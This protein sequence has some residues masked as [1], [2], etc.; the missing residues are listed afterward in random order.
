[1]PVDTLTLPPTLTTA[2]L[3]DARDAYAS[4]AIEGTSLSEAEAMELAAEFYASDVPERVAALPTHPEMSYEE[5]TAEF[6]RAG[7]LGN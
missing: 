7:L 6:A 1:M 2:Q 5:L 4:A 3:D